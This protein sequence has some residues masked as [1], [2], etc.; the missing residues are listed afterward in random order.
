MSNMKPAALAALPALRR[1]DHGLALS[2]GVVD[3][4]GAL[5][6]GLV[7]SGC[8]LAFAGQNHG[9]RCELGGWPVK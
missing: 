8:A 9:L 1:I 7:H 6:L 5:A 2:L 3:G 4:G